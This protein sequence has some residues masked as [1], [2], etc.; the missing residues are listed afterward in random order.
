MF[1]TWDG[2]AN[3]LVLGTVRFTGWYL[4]RFGLLVGTG[5]GSDNW[6]VLGTVRVT[7]WYWGRFG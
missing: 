1:G 3:R 2:S 5:D 7:G 6:L 4:E